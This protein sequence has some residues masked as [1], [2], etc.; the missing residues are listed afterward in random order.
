MQQNHH[1]GVG[2]GQDLFLCPH[3]GGL[4]VVIPVGIGVAPTDGLVAQLLG[5]FQILLAETS[6]GR[7]VIGGHLAADDLFI[8][9][10]KSG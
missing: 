1:T 6:L 10:F 9:L 7:A 2:V 4:S 3:G 8:A 5:V